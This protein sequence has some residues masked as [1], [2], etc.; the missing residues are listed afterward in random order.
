MVYR[1][2]VYVSLFLLA[3]TGCSSN[4]HREQREG[5]QL[6]SLGE[7]SEAQWQG[8]GRRKIFY[9]H[10]SVGRNILQGIR[11]LEAR[12]SRI[13]LNIVSS[14]APEQVE[15]P[16]LVEYAIGRNGDPE[17]KEQ[18]FAAIMERGMG[19]QGGIAMYKYCYLDT[20]PSTNPEEM[21]ARYRA[22]VAALQHKYPELVIMH[23]TSPL[24]S[25]ESPLKYWIKKA[26]LRATDRDLNTKRNRYNEL[27]RNE[28]AGKAPIFDLA[29]VESTRPD[30]SRSFLLRDGKP[31]YTLALE[32]TDDGGHLNELGRRV[33]AEQLLIV[34]SSLPMDQGRQSAPPVR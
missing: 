3:L 7:V 23:V 1:K 29:K 15:G 24:T 19:R 10:Q 13:R 18:A 6:R 30:G 16:A 17:S 9:G 33:A 20:L 22:N 8:L 5:D 11:E 28:Y 14:A 2:I 21:F 12:D 31:V 34:L 4:D 26:L 27:L 25:V 32:Y